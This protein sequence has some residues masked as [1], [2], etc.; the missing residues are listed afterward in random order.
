MTTS[1]TTYRWSRALSPKQGPSRRFTPRPKEIR[2]S[3]ARSCVCWPRRANSRPVG[4]SLEIPAG[5]R[6]VIGS[7]V[8]RLTEPCRKLLSIASVLGRE[9][10]V[11]VL[12]YVSEFQKETLYDALD[13]A[14]A[15]RIIGEV[16]GA[17]EP[18]AVRTRPDSRH[19]LRGP[20]RGAKDATSSRSGHGTRACTRRS[21][22]H[23]WRRSRCISSLLGP[24]PVTKPS[25]S[26]DARRI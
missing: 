18:H 9:F 25:I 3:S 6:E 16:P 8:A 7:R 5:I 4:H 2:C 11:E 26:R 14:M 19:S 15:E 13:E 24:S 21:S 1:P 23:I 20:D 17:S 12:Q 10:G 22:S